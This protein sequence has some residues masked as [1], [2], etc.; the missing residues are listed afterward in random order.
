MPNRPVIDMVQGRPKAVLSFIFIFASIH[1][2]TRAEFV[3]R[4]GR[5]GSKLPIYISHLRFMLM[6][7]VTPQFTSGAVLKALIFNLWATRAFRAAY[8]PELV[9]RL[10]SRLRV[11][12]DPVIKTVYN[13]AALPK[14]P[15]PKGN[16]GIAKGLQAALQNLF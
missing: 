13:N 4:P 12:H 14:S 9:P 2:P 7:Y 11:H 3:V 15:G 10:E 5:R 8:R 16:R 1:A 6:S